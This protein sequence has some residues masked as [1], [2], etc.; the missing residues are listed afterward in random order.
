MRRTYM[1][2]IQLTTSNQSSLSKGRYE[3]NPWSYPVLKT[4][5]NQKQNKTVKLYENYRVLFSFLSFLT[6][7]LVV[8]PGSTFF[9]PGRILGRIFPF[10]VL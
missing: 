9:R 3:K 1:T 5:V 2:V 8:P 7:R 10:V 6:E 4:A